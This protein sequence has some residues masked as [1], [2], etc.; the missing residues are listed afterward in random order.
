MVQ[1]GLANTGMPLDHGLVATIPGWWRYISR[2]EPTRLLFPG[3][4][5][6]CGRDRDTCKVGDPHLPAEC[7]KAVCYQCSKN[8]HRA[9]ECPERHRD[10]DEAQTYAPSVFLPDVT[11]TRSNAG[12]ESRTHQDQ[13]S[14]SSIAPDRDN[15]RNAEQHAASRTV[16]F[17]MIGPYTQDQTGQEASAVVQDVTPSTRAGAS[18]SPWPSQPI[19][20]H[21]T[22]AQQ[23]Q[24]D[25]YAQEE[26]LVPATP[27]ER[28]VDT[29]ANLTPFLAE[30]GP[31]TTSSLEA[32]LKALTHSRDATMTLDRLSLN[33]PAETGQ[34]STP[35][36]QLETPGGDPTLSEG[37]RANQEKPVSENAQAFERLTVAFLAG[38]TTPAVSPGAEMQAESQETAIV[39]GPELDPTAPQATAPGDQQMV[40][41]DAASETRAPLGEGHGKKRAKTPKATQV[42]KTITKTTRS[43]FK[44]LGRTVQRDSE[45]RRGRPPRSS[46]VPA[47]ERFISFSPCD[48]ID[49]HVPEI[50]NSKRLSWE[51]ERRGRSRSRSR[52]PNARGRAPPN[53]QAEHRHPQHPQT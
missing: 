38:T 39:A 22:A 18:G 4:T 34:V 27:T 13:G 29:A 19:L 40:D 52:S 28:I 2:G 51:R 36:P 41:V 45:P 10:P 26:V 15:A 1:V 12:S 48:F 5:D 21:R 23:E 7:P 11:T 30:T 14:T 8:G 6:W 33:P 20:K 16:H 44:K 35:G 37:A 43:D 32:R 47:G 42:K 49:G 9:R 24:P 31:T 50:P 3:R 53:Q 17:D 46:S 25:S